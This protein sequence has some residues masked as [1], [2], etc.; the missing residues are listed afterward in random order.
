MPRCLDMVA[1]RGNQLPRNKQA[2]LIPR[3]ASALN[4]ALLQ[5]LRVCWTLHAV[6]GLGLGQ[7]GYW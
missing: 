5:A 4:L 1:G 3:A 7:A 2:R 6:P